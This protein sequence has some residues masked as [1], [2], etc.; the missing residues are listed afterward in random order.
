MSALYNDACFKSRRKKKGCPGAAFLNRLSLFF[1][2]LPLKIP[3]ISGTF[4][5][6]QISLLYNHNTHTGDV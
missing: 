4:S 1:K 2:P 6:L 5:A 3:P